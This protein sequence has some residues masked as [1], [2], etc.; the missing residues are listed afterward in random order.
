MKYTVKYKRQNQWFFRTIKNV[1]GDG[2]I[3]ENGVVVSRFFLTEEEDRIE[4][5]V[6]AIFT[7]DKG[8]FFSIQYAKEQQTG[9][10]LNPN[11]KARPP[12]E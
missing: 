7:F 3:V 9:Q 1:K 11:T 5:P 6:D 10:K 4:V 12:K 8:R 2:F